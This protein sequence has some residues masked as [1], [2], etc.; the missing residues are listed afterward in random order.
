MKHGARLVGPDPSAGREERRNA[1][2]LR[3]GEVAER[4]PFFAGEW[5]GFLDWLLAAGRRPVGLEIVPDPRTRQRDLREGGF[6]MCLC[7]CPREAGEVFRHIQRKHCLPEVIVEVL[8][9]GGMD[10]HSSAH[11]HSL[12]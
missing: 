4:E 6:D 5:Q 2:G 7:R 1:A 3:A 8:A 10:G 11:A 9:R 12:A